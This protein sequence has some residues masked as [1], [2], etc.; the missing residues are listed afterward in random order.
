MP[1]K[2][3]DK[4]VPPA[5]RHDEYA[6]PARRGFATTH[7]SVVLAAGRE[8]ESGDAALGRLCETYWEPIYFFLRGQGRSPEE[9]MDLTQGFLARLLERRDLGVPSPERGRFRAYLLGALRHFMLNESRRERARKRGGGA[10]ILSLD[11]QAA[12]SHFALEPADLRTP[13]RL[14]E[15]R[16]ALATL[17]AVLGK[18]ERECAEEGKS[19]LF[20]R[21]KGHLAGERQDARYGAIAADLGMTEGA[22]KAAA[23][24]LRSRYRTLL[25][26]TIADTLS[27][28]AQIDEEI[29]HLIAALEP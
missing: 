9:A 18:L 24:R 3:E 8:G 26:A 6:D 19:A 7:W 12:E 28:P 22:V 11:F 21:L 17:E 10:P 5:D 2:S 4:S 13:E 15:R 27:Q 1:E 14:Y 25:R 20:A 29:R 23:H 16:W